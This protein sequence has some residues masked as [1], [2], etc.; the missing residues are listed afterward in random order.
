[1]AFTPG[2]YQK[3]VE[4]RSRVWTL[5]LSSRFLRTFLASPNLEQ[6][7]IRYDHGGAAIDFEQREYTH[8]ELLF[9]GRRPPPIADHSI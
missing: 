6:H 4:R 8:C 1:L 3:P 7:V 9:V 2:E 5:H